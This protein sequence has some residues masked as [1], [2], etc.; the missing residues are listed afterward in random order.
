MQTV[1]ARVKR[2]LQTVATFLNEEYP[3]LLA[4]GP[5]CGDGVVIET[6]RGKRLVPDWPAAFELIGTLAD[7]RFGNKAKCK[8]NC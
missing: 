6:D 3:K 4:I 8:G 7:P 5:M 2:N 1:A